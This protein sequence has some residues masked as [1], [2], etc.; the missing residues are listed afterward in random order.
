MLRAFCVGLLPALIFGSLAASS[1][2]GLGCS[3]RSD[4]PGN[5]ALHVHLTGEPVTL[6]P[7]LAEDG[8]SIRILGNVMEGLMGYDASGKLV[9]RLA[10][11]HE[12]QAAGMRY[13]FTLKPEARWSDGRRVQA[14]EFVAGI[15]RA[16][17]PG[18]PSK[19]AAFLLPIR[20]AAEFHSGKARELNGV[21][22]EGGKVVVELERPIGY[23]LHAFALPATLP[24]RED[25]LARNEGAWP[26]GKRAQEAVFTGPY[27][28]VSHEPDK[29][30]L[31]ERNPAYRGPAA[32]IPVVHLDIVRDE[33]TAVNLFE[34]GKLDILSRVPAL[35]YQRLRQ[36]GGIHIDP[37]RATYYLGFN[38]R[39]SPFDDRD[40]RRAVAASIRKRDLTEALQ[41]GET[42]AR[43][44]IPPGLEGFLPEDE[45]L[46]DH[47]RAV[48]KVKTQLAGGRR[49]H[50]VTAVFDSGDR[51]ALVLEKVQHDL[52]EELGL[53][54]TLSSLDWKTHIRN[55]QTDPAQLF[56]FG[57]LA[58]FDDPITHLRIFA[59]GN[60]NNY[61]GCSLPDYDERV[62]RVEALPP[63]PERERNIREAQ[64]ILVDREAVIVPLFHYV[65]AH[66]VRPRVKNF[67]VNPFGVI[68]LDELEL[69]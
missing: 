66:A 3:R 47:S 19:T 22:D 37:F 63:G 57:W 69:N 33:T 52:R 16:L 30:I 67:R 36:R 24:V 38:C 58:P 62:R 54:V 50:A 15:R 53:K 20:G 14:A 12:V 43:G 13:E 55:L 48:A 27:R 40:W 8:L 44:W 4:S 46:P 10:E 60:P 64:A 61:T 56:R 23:F 68:R 18:M 1:G 59:T 41:T 51:N 32:R 9:A 6:D 2:F 65:Q 17:A 11:S 34:R 21:R 26:S 45:P 29:R 28:I 39:K 35:E 25:V 49:R 7:A 5:A 31:L 42:P